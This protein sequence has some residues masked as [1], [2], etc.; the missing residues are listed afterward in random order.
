VGTSTHATHRTDAGNFVRWAARQKLT[1]L[2]FAAVKWTGP[3]GIIDTETRWSQARWLLDDTV[4]PEDR[5]AGLL[6]LLYA[7]W[8]AAI[9]RLTLGHVRIDDDV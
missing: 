7:Q 6:V 4:K 3:S 1:R 9:S 8:P 5:L 2:D